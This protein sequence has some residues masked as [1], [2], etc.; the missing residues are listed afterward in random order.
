VSAAEVRA[1]AAE[2][3]LACAE[4]A[5]SAHQGGSIA[6]DEDGYGVESIYDLLCDLRHLADL[7]E[8]DW[9]TLIRMAMFHYD[10]EVRGDQ[11]SEMEA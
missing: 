6:Y 8:M 10:A 9:P 1:R 4:N 7:W 11:F 2:R 5:V 3:R